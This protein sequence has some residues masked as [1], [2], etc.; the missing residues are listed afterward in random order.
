MK[1]TSQR[2][3]HFLPI[4]LAIVTFCLILS[5]QIVQAQLKAAG[6]NV[7]NVL[8]F[9][10]FDCNHCQAVKDE[11]L[12]P[13]EQDYGKNLN[14]LYIEIGS[15]KNYE[16][17]IDL[18]VYY[19]IPA[20]KRAI[21]TM[22]I[23][24]TILIG[25]N[26]IRNQFPSIVDENLETGI[27]WT[28]LPG[29]V[30]S[31]YEADPFSVGGA[32]VF[33]EEEA[34]GI[35]DETC[36]I[37]NPIFVAYFYQTGCKVCSRVEADLKYMQTK[38]PQIIVD[39]FNIYENVDLGQW[40]MKQAKRTDD[41]ATPALFINDTMLIGEEE[42]T[43]ASIEA[44]VVANESG[45]EGIWHN[46]DGDEDTATD[47]FENL[48][49]LTIGFAGLIDGLNPCAFATLIFFVSYLSLSQRQGREIL[50]CGASFTAGVFLAYLVV[51]LGFYQIL[52]L[53]GGM[54]QLLSNIV[55]GL[56]AVFCLVLAVLSFRDA[57]RVKKGGT[58]DMGLHLPEKLRK[59][60]NSRIR[61]GRKASAYVWFAFITGLIIS[62]LELACTGQIYLPTII[63]MTSQDSMQLQAIFYL[64]LYNLMFI[65][66]LIIVFILAYYGTNSKD[67][68]KFLEKH[69]T[70]I[71]IGMSILFS[72]LGIW[73]IYSIFK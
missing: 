36:D 57:L 67:L 1:L 14:I 16:L 42:I 32:G 64:L 49:W 46:F 47:L 20:E 30:A 11:L 37:E 22:V 27:N 13:M 29:F 2:K 10:S 17:L 51:G 62:M 45:A 4:L 54:L 7:I 33:D 15:A 18:E 3:L 69:A 41:V 61:A 21:P 34:C 71:K 60:I 59:Q 6:H 31:D 19:E 43:P 28:S 58:A 24:D 68:T 52:D 39:E 25:E 44:L 48:S 50:F 5:P 66:P 63:F 23:G 56:T 72:A 73:L 65:I 40:L 55:Y 53:L 35:E 38:Y 70:K 12:V 8:Y 26:E 9:Y